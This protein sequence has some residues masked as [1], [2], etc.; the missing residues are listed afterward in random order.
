MLGLGEAMIDIVAGAGHDESM[1]PEELLALDLLLDVSRGPTVAGRIGEVS[2]IVR[3]DGVDLIRHG[4]DKVLQEV[5]G[6]APGGFL[7]QL[8][9]GEL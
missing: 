9:V 3:E 1:G 6:D 2:A 7:V 8:C 5:G 4:L